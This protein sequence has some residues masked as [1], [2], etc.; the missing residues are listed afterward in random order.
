MLCVMFCVGHTVNRLSKHDDS[1]VAHKAAAV[2][3]A[4]KKHFEDKR[5]M[6]LIEVKCDKRTEDLRAVGRKHLL[7]SLSVTEELPVST[8]C[9]YTR[10]LNESFVLHAAS[11]SIQRM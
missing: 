8:C 9:I 4:W 10:S 1:E 2:V 5:D 3:K 11:C 6:P 7:R